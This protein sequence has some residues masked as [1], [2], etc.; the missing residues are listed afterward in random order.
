MLSS[1]QEYETKELAQFVSEQV[2]KEAKEKVYFGAFYD[3]IAYNERGQ[4]DSTES[5]RLL[6]LQVQD[7]VKWLKAQGAI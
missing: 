5:K 3:P 6:R 4:A 2:K 1:V 7:F